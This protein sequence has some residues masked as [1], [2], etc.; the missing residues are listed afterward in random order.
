MPLSA[1]LAFDAGTFICFDDAAMDI[2]YGNR[3]WWICSTEVSRLRKTPAQLLEDATVKRVLYLNGQVDAAVHDKLKKILSGDLQVTRGEEDLRLVRTLKRALVYTGFPT[4]GVGG[5]GAT[6]SYKTSGGYDEHMSNGVA[7]LLREWAPEDLL[8]DAGNPIS[9][10]TL[11]FRSSYNGNNGV[12]VTP[13]VLREFPTVPVRSRGLAGLLNAIQGLT[14]RR[15][16]Y[17]GNPDAAIANLD[18]LDQG[19][20]PSTQEIITRYK[21]GILKLLRESY[22]DLNL[23]PIWVATVILNETHGLPVPKFE[24]H[25]FRDYYLRLASGRSW[26]RSTAAER[27]QA[28][29]EYFDDP[30]KRLS[31][32]GIK[33][34][35]MLCTS[36]GL[37]QIMGFNV[38]DHQVKGRD[39]TLETP[40][41]P[42]QLLMADE[43][44][45]VRMVLGHLIKPRRANGT[46]PPSSCNC[47]EAHTPAT[48]V[49]VLEQTVVNGPDQCRA[50]ACAFNG[51][52]YATKGYHNK[53]FRNFQEVKGVWDTLSGT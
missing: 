5:V 30:T 14:Q 7:L 51:A 12:P 2:A 32:E 17:L 50:L 23:N 27:D 20:Y 48:P 34:A 39:G 26:G 11:V 1:W 3:A 13:D 29:Q 31:A 47:D 49:A 4:F 16:I 38:G 10:A 28:V 35:R 24:H 43:E 6:G 21:E 22:S 46:R 9:E 42:Q 53:T 19:R 18:L 36:Y 41:H 15:E 8:D 25:L 45:Q 37:G 33:H 44:D 40:T 52:Q